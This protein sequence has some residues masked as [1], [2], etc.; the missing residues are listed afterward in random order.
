MQA[1]KPE[2]QLVE[3]SRVNPGWKLPHAELC[4]QARCAFKAGVLL[5]A[6]LGGAASA[7]VIAPVLAESTSGATCWQRGLFALMV[8]QQ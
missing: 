2:V 7:R 3:K 1:R 4:M 5:A 8:Q 6:E